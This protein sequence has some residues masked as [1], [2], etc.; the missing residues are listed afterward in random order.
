MSLEI[1]RIPMAFVSWY[2]KLRNTA[3][4][5]LT[6]TILVSPYKCVMR[7]VLTYITTFLSHTCIFASAYVQSYL[8]V[9]VSDGD[10]H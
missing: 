8:H 1:N 9:T 6:H 3:C 2:R 10:A 5:T 7:L 4:L